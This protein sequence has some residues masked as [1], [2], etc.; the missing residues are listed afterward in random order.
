MN[1]VHRQ[2]AGFLA[3]AVLLLLVFTGFPSVYVIWLGL[4][5]ASLLAPEAGFVGADNYLRVVADARFWNAL[6][7]TVYFTVVSVSVELALGLGIALLLRHA[8]R[9]QGMMRALVLVPWMVPT[10]VSAR[11]FEW[12]YNVEF[13]VLNY[14]LGAPV[15]WLGDPTLAIHAA[16]AADV[17][18]MTPFVAL[19]LLAGLQGIPRDLYR[20]A[21]VDGASAWLMFRRITLPQLAP[22]I[23]IVLILRVIDA[24]RVFDVVYV[25]TGGGPGNST[26]T[27]SIYAY[28]ILFQTL[29][30]GYGSALAAVTFA[31]VALI[32]VGFTL[33]LRR[34][35]Q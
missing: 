7:N 27:L 18:K 3:P 14:L 23:L 6:W 17:W 19:L 22:L 16:I 24:F 8:F 33:R 30:F 4:T 10:V 25:L 21:R 12:M 13:G 20:A 11:M 34:A 1:G 31:L 28:K 29:D 15:N 32:T 9:G 5:D 26:E 35:W 2:A